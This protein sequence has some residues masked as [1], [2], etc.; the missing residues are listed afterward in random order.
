M[1]TDIRKRAIRRGAIRVGPFIPRPQMLVKDA[2]IPAKGKDKGGW[3]VLPY[4][5]MQ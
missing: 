1:L 4:G 5:V 2:S 3:R